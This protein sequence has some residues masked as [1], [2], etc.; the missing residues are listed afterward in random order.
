MSGSVG[1]IV[2]PMAGRDIRRLVASASLQSGPEKILAA[3]RIVAGVQAVE[4][5]TL[6]MAD[7]QQGFARFLADEVGNILHLVPIST[8]LEGGDLTAYWAKALQD[9]GAEALLVV[10]GDGTQRNVAQAEITVPVL[11]VAG[12]TN[13]VACWTGDQTAAGYAAA[14]YVARGEDPAQV[15]YR[16][17]VI[18]V[19]S[20]GHEERALIDVALVRVLYTGAMAVWRGSDVDALVLAVADPVR[21]G[22][23]NVGGYIYPVTAQEDQ[24]LYLELTDDPAQTVWNGSAVLAPGLM[25]SLAI[26]G[27]LPLSLGQEVALSRTNGGTLALDGERTVVL[28]PGQ[29]AR[30]TVRRDGPFVLDPERVF[31]RTRNEGVRNLV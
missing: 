19:I 12:G 28:R 23:S 16:A 9:A 8:D 4:G 26:K 22:L 11:P 7:D 2:N 20:D 29:I 21:P 27:W 15:G 1:L 10:G 6:L 13:N 25:D 24:A 17:K 14:L 31:K 3:K 18:H 5:M 30:I